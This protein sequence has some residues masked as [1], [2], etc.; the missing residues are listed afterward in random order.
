MLQIFKDDADEMKQVVQQRATFVLL[1]VALF[2]LIMFVVGSMNVI[3]ISLQSIAC[4][5]NRFGNCTCNGI[6]NYIQ[7]SNHRNKIVI[8]NWFWCCVNNV[9]LLVVCVIEMNNEFFL[10][11]YEAYMIYSH[12]N[13]F[14]KLSSFD[15]YAYKKVQY[16]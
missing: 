15:F 12:V 8:F 3:M 10:Q 11:Y 1:S 2:V 4:V 13:M 7:S 6:C 14:R 5:F 9:F 16:F